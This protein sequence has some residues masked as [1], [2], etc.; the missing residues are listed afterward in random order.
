[1]HKDLI[2]LGIQL[3]VLMI[4]YLA[5]EGA[6][7]F[8]LQLNLRHLSR[9]GGEVPPDF[10]EHVDA[11]T[12]R[13]MRDY[14]VAH[15]RAETIESLISMLI[16]LLFVFGGLL[17]WFNNFIAA[18]G[19]SPVL[20]GVVFYLLLVY[21]GTFLNI[22]FSLYNT[23]VLEKR[24]GFSRQ[25]PAFWLQD[26]LKSLLVST[27]LL[28]TLFY[29]IL[30]LVM[31]L[32]ELWWLAGWFFMFCFSLF[33]LYLSPYVIEPLFNK[34]IPIKDVSLEKHIKET[35]ARAG[36]KINRVFS[37]DASK[38][39]SHSNAYFT[40]IGHVKRIVLYDTLLANHT[41]DEIIAIL[42]HEA[43][44]WKK[45]HILKML[46]L[47][48]A[49]SLLGFYG[50]YL[51]TAGNLL[52]GIFQL[53]IPSMPAKLLLAV[54]IGSLVLFPLRPL[55]SYLSRRHEIEADNFAVKLTQT[56]VPLAHALMKLGKD[57][58]A[59]LHPHPW[60]AAVYYSHP[61]LVQR[62]NRL[63]AEKK[64]QGE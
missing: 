56:P 49:G 52:P 55:I 45:K 33:V 9:L 1:M 22:P 34:F 59:N 40:G 54:F 28:G 18:Q 43:G 24:F 7:Q 15:G 4:I 16:T 6:E 2:V 63:L 35:M 14:T 21:A 64:A 39:S 30:W 31:A 50:A 44:H 12:L 36:L 60:Y 53:D 46:V 17:N 11:G 57:N 29:G 26:L 27:L 62:V 3:L 8:L 37:M 20:S 48:Q 61:P 25:T 32:P 5:I 38:R 47:S 13:K 23:F 58:L 42:A 19:W 10:M 41:A 51:L